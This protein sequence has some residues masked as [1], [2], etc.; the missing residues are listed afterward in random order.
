MW[1][2]RPGQ[3]DK[4]FLLGKLLHCESRECAVGIRFGTNTALLLWR[5]IG[6][7]GRIFSLSQILKTKEI[8]GVDALTL[9]KSRNASGGTEHGYFPFGAIQQNLVDTL[10]E[11][12]SFAKGYLNLPLPLK[13]EVG[14]TGIEGYR[15]TMPSGSVTNF[16]GHMVVDDISYTGQIEDYIASPVELLKPFFDK[17][18]QECGLPPRR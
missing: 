8:W 18:W 10:G 7:P 14:A 17:L 5:G 16:G 4:L 2:D 12:L 15:M 9:T 13:I 3:C 11:Y 1:R 6:I